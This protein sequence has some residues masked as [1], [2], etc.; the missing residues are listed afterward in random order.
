EGSRGGSLLLQKPLVNIRA[1][2]GETPISAL[3]L[4]RTSR[5]SNPA[6][7]SCQNGADTRPLSRVWRTSKSGRLKRTATQ[8]VGKLFGAAKLSESV[9]PNQAHREPPRATMLSCHR[10]ER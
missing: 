1:V 8:F 4:W 7:A 5:K 6:D 2:T 9:V 3:A 10:P